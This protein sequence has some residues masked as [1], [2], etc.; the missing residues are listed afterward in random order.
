MIETL[1]K[2][3]LSDMLFHL[4]LSKDNNRFTENHI[5]CIIP[6]IIFWKL[7]FIF[8]SALPRLLCLFHSGVLFV[9]I[10][11]VLKFQSVL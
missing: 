1:E 5:L 11:L 2:K 4:L 6:Y 9:L 8:L 10:S 7:N 3:I